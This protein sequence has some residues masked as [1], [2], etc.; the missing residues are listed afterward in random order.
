M[1]RP[2]KVQKRRPVLSMAIPFIA[3]APTR[4][5]A[6]NCRQ[7]GT[8][9]CTVVNWPPCGGPLTWPIP[10]AHIISPPT[11]HWRAAHIAQA[12]SRSTKC[13]P[14]AHQSGFDGPQVG[15]AAARRRFSTPPQF[16]GTLSRPVHYLARR[17]VLESRMVGMDECRDGHIAQKCASDLFFFL[18][19]FGV[20]ATSSGLASLWQR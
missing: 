18:G 6:P 12:Q 9:I 10:A 11:K 15:K 5:A 14:E 4:D 20:L 1:P 16:L 19:S 7:R 8:Q 13:G 17:R 2:L 3:R